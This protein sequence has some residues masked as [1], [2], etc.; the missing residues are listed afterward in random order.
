MKWIAALFVASLLAAGTFGVAAC[1]TSSKT[2]P[3]ATLTRLD[4]QTMLRPPLSR[5]HGGYS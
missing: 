2:P 4:T 1:A 3:P 5:P